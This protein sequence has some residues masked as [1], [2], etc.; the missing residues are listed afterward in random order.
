MRPLFF[1]PLIFA[2]SSKPKKDQFVP[3]CTKGTDAKCKNDEPEYGILAR[4]FVF[5]P[6]KANF[7]SVHW[8]IRN[9]LN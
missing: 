6:I 1:L 3:K 7:E 9:S 8:K 2:G 4:K 5:D